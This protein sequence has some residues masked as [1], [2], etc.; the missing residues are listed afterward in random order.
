[1][2]RTRTW[3]TTSGVDGPPAVGWLP[4]R[5]S[6]LEQQPVGCGPPGLFHLVFGSNHVHHSVDQ[7]QMGEG[8]REVAE[9]AA[10]L[11]VDLLGVELE[12]TGEGEQPFAELT[13]APVLPDGRQRGDQP[14]RADR[15]SALLA[16]EAVV[17]LLDPIAQDQL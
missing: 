15:K 14:E 8:L 16:A 11:S 13:G 6:C 4:G 5:H 1:L 17:G 9:V 10:V 7:R 2:A 3:S 12:W